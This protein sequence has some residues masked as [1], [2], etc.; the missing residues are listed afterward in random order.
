MEWDVAAHLQQ[1]VDNGETVLSLAL[2]GSPVIDQY[3]TFA[4]KESS[5]EANG[6]SSLWILMT[7]WQRQLTDEPVVT[8]TEPLITTTWNVGYHGTL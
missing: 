3:S 7:Q 4:S 6:P 2:D 1:L 5:N 8:T